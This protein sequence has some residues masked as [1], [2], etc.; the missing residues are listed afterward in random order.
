MHGKQPHCHQGQQLDDRFKRHGQHQTGAVL[1]GIHLARAEQN[2][3]QGHDG[4]HIQG[5]VVNGLRAGGRAGQNLQ[6]DGH[7]LVLQGQIGHGGGQRDDRD[8]GAE[9]GALAEPRRQEIPD[10]RD[11]VCARDRDQAHEEGRAEQEDE[12]GTEV[13]R[14]VGPAVA[15]GRA[16]GAE[17]RPGRAVDAEREAV[18]VRAQS[19]PARIDRFALAV[20][21][22]G[23]QQR[24]VRDGE[25][26]EEQPGD[27]ARTVA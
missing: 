17:E 6:A 15:D 7:R 2:G 12:G 8:E 21:R 23:E 27:H 20:E 14:Q 3:E 10:R 26:G 13:D 4:R 1:G 19:R 5:R 25:S 16:H 24:E 11:V 18:D 22:H 9:R